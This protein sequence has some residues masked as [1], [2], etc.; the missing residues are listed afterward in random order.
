M[1]EK[2]RS[3]KEESRGAREDEEIHEE[4][5]ERVLERPREKGKTS[6]CCQKVSE[7]RKGKGY[8][9]E[10]QGENTEEEE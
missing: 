10:E 4:I 3:K 2:L 1:E 9:K 8:D 5:Y 6:G 7:K